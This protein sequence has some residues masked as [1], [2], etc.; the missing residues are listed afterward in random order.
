VEVNELHNKIDKL[1]EQNEE[2]LQEIDYVYQRLNNSE[3][4]VDGNLIEYR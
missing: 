3:C 4:F 1:T 2:I